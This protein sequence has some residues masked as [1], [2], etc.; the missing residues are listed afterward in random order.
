MGT[1]PA[2]HRR[3]HAS[4]LGIF[5][6][7]TGPHTSRSSKMVVAPS[8]PR[9]HSYDGENPFDLVDSPYGRIE[10]WRAVALSTG[11]VSAMTVLSKQIQNDAMATIDDIE[12]RET[13]LAA[14][15]EACDA[16]EKAHAVSVA[17]FVDFVGRAA[18]LFDRIEKQRADAIAG[19]EPLAT[20]PGTPPDNQ[21]KLPEPSV[22]SDVTP[23][24]HTPGGELHVVAAKENPETAA[25]FLRLKYPVSMDQAEF[26]S[27]E[28]PRPPEVQ[29]PV[30]D[31]Q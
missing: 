26:P 10:R 20:P 1:H 24:Q 7:A 12:A 13:A 27:G 4:I 19:A 17:R 22:E 21:H 3:H 9:T 16:R 31:E 8:H 11:E 23:G 5:S 30:A 14:R 25:D 18:V 28:L 15:E 6:A 29:Q 2:I